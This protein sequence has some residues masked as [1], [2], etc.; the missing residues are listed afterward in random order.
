LPTPSKFTQARRRRILEALAAGGSRREA[1]TAAGIDHATLTRWLARGRKGAAG[2]SWRR[3]WQD[4]ERAEADP[5]LLA[6]RADYE[7]WEEE[8]ARAWRFLQ[9]HEQE[10]TDPPIASEGPLVIHLKFADR[11]PLPRQDRGPEEDD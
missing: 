8:P 4:V 2:G 6:L 11:E 5:H 3:F 7:L 10:F 9:R 1:A